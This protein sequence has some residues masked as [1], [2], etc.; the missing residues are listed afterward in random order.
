MTDTITIRPANPQ[1][2]E[3]LSGIAL[4]SKSYWGYSA[5]FIEACRA[6]L[7]ISET[8]ITD[9]ER[10]YFAA[11]SNDEVIGFYALERLSANEY[12]LEALFVEP[13]RIGQGIGKALINH[14]KSTAREL[15]A[16]SLLIQ[17]DPNATAFYLAT[18]GVLIGERQS[19]SISGRYLPE[20]RIS[21]DAGNTT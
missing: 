20:F 18:G 6:E 12:E 10:H 13:Q 2:D 3:L 5:E 4:R 9:K 11:E 21:L 16:R 17:S 8:E 1:D 7:S 19:N 14:A 15:G